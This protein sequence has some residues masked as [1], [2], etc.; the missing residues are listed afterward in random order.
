MLELQKKQI[1]MS[2]SKNTVSAQVTFDED[3]NIPDAKPDVGSVLLKQADAV[4]EELRQLSEKVIIKGRLDFEILY[5]VE[6][7]G[8]MKNLSGALTFEENVSYP[9]LEPGDY[10]RC[11]TKVEDISIRVVNSR[12]L[13]I[14]LHYCFHMEYSIFSILV[15]MN[16][17]LF[18]YQNWLHRW[19]H[20]M[21]ASNKR[22]FSCK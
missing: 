21:T 16:T 17:N 2:R 14:K 7:S 5:A 19:N 11:R 8:R 18:F 1:H 20:L 12:K 10:V 13:H 6:G 4:M 15:W 3:F 22:Q 9:G